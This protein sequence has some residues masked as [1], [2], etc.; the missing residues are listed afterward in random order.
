MRADKITSLYTADSQAAAF[1][2]QSRPSVFPLN[3]S[4]VK[5]DDFLASQQTRLGAAA[6]ALCTALT[7]LNDV[8]E[9]TL[10]GGPSQASDIFSADPVTP[11]GRAEFARLMSD[12]V[13][14]PLGH[15]LRVLAAECSL[16]CRV[17]VS[18]AWTQWW[19]FKPERTFLSLFDGDID[20][21][22]QTL[23]HRREA[24]GAFRPVHAFPRKH[25]RDRGPRQEHRHDRQPLKGNY[26]HTRTG[27]NDN[28]V[29]GQSF[30]DSP[31]DSQSFSYG[32]GRF[33]RGRGGGQRPSFQKKKA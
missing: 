13:A 21:V 31:R 8:T 22:V 29:N 30:R 16:L 3:E 27:Q 28:A 14:T 7:R 33:P 11:D 26:G 20:A 6:H 2:A 19:T 24:E 5:R 17:A 9:T 15:V 12:Q 18:S 32:K 23:R 25:A 10:L 1:A 4:A